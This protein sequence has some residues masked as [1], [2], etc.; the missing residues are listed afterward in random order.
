LPY[1]LV[2]GG[3]QVAGWL[4]R[5]WVPAAAACLAVLA[6]TGIWTRGVLAEKEALWAGSEAIRARGVDPRRIFGHFEWECYHG[7]FDDYLEDIGREL[8]SSPIG[9]SDGLADFFDRFLE[10]RKERGDHYVYVAD[11]EDVGEGGPER[12]A[13]FP[14]TN[15]LLEPKAVIAERAEKD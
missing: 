10:E 11:A 14:F 2:A 5:V 9:Q 6:L 7:A 3:R 15:M 13:V 8:V 12:I 4:D 1:A